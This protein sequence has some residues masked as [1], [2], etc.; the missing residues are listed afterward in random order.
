MNKNPHLRHFLTSAKVVIECKVCNVAEEH[1]DI[2]C[3]TVHFL[4]SFISFRVIWL[5]V[6][7][8]SITRFHQHIK[9]MK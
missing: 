3:R 2:T 6:E 8:V 4:V 7:T 9:V 5:R 1:V